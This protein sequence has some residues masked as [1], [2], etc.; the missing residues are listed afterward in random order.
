MLRIIAETRQN[1]RTRGMRPDD[2]LLS[3]YLD[4]EVPDRFRPEIESAITN[5]PKTRERYAALQDLRASLH[6]AEVP[7]LDERMHAS[8]Q[9][10]QRR[11]SV[12]RPPVYSVGR[13]RQVRL[14]LPVLAAAAAV[15]RRVRRLPPR[16]ECRGPRDS[17]DSHRDPAGR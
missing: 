5:D 1:Q 2:V 4:G 7:E 14:P 10:I 9:S 6:R 12:R 8:W 13:F 15:A 11:L 17:T 16:D 3:A